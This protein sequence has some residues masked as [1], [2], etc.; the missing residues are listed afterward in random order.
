MREVLVKRTKQAP[1]SISNLCSLSPSHTYPTGDPQAQGLENTDTAYSTNFSVK[2]S[3]LYLY[4]LK[5]EILEHSK[6][7]KIAIVGYYSSVTSP[8]NT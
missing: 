4:L 1:H 6:P 8:P 7:Y 3:I 2:V 5:P